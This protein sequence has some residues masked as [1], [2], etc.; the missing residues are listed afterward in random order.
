MWFLTFCSSFTAGNI[1][2]FIKCA[3]YFLCSSFYSILPFNYWR[4]SQ[5]SWDSDC[6]HPL[7]VKRLCTS[8]TAGNI[9]LFMKS[10]IYFIVLIPTGQ[11]YTPKKWNC[12]MSNS[13]R[14][15]GVQLSIKI[16]LHSQAGDIQISILSLRGENHIINQPLVINIILLY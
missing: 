13:E 1:I 11:D 15:S 8:F 2:L 9:I 4:T 5:I 3:S 12:R 7:R 10:D 14:L 6:E 16:R